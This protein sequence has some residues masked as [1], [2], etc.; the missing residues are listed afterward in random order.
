M[1]QKFPA[2]FVTFTEEIIPNGKLHYLCSESE[3]VFTILASKKNIK[4]KDEVFRN[5]LFFITYAK[6]SKKLIILN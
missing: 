3:S 6:F 5:H 4:V 2:D 1:S